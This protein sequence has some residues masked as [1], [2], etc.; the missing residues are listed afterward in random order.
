MPKSYLQSFNKMTD[1]KKNMLAADS[2]FL[3]SFLL[4]ESL[5]QGSESKPT[6]PPFQPSEKELTVHQ[7]KYE[8]YSTAAGRSF[9]LAARK[10][11]PFVSAE[12]FQQWSDF[13]IRILETAHT[14]SSLVQCFFD[15]S[16]S[17]FIK[18]S[19]T[20]LRA[21][22]EKGLQVAALSVDTAV[23][24]YELT[25]SFIELSNNIQL[26]KWGDWCLHLINRDEPES[27]LG[28]DFL[29]HSIACL[30]FMT[31]REFREYKN[32]GFKFFRIAPDI[33]KQFF[34]EVVYGLGDLD[35]TQRRTLYKLT[36]RISRLD[37][38]EAFSFFKNYPRQLKEISPNERN[39]VLST[40]EKLTHED[41]GKISFLFSGLISTLKGQPY[42]RQILILDECERII[43]LSSAA[44]QA[45]L[46]TANE[47]LSRIP[48]CFLSQF[49][50]VG[51][52]SFSAD[53]PEMAD[54]FALNTPQ[55]IRELEKFAA[56]T[57]FEDHQKTLMVLA[58]AMTGVFTDV[59]NIQ[60]LEN[61][62]DIAS[63]FHATTDGKTIY[64]P[65]FL[66]DA[67]SAKK[68]FN[69]YKI[70]TAHQAGLIEFKTFTRDLPVM[71]K[72]LS[73]LPQ[74]Q[75]AMDVF[76]ILEHGRI[77]FQLARNYAG[78]K[79]MMEQT[80]W[81][82]INQRALPETL[83]LKEAV[84]EILL[85][86]SVIPFNPDYARSFKT[87]SEYL[88][89][90]IAFLNH[91]LAGFYEQNN[92]VWYCFEKTYDI[93]HH[94][95][96]LPN[97]KQGLAEEP[98]H[99]CPPLAYRGQTYPSVL[100]EQGSEN[101]SSKLPDIMP[102]V[103]PQEQESGY[104]V[105][106]DR[107]PDKIKLSRGHAEVRPGIPLGPKDIS[108]IMLDHEDVDDSPNSKLPF[109]SQD[110]I[111]SDV[112]AMDTDGFYLY[113]EWDYVQS[114]YRKKWCRLREVKQDEG[115]LDKIN[116]IHAQ[117]RHLIQ[118]VKNQFQ[119]IKP[120]TYEN[121]PRVDWGDEIDLTAVIEGVVDKK[122]GNIPSD[123]VF[124][125]KDRK[126]QSLSVMFLV[127]MSASTGSPVIA[128][129]KSDS[130]P[131]LAREYPEQM[132]SE[133]L[134]APEKK[135]IDIEIESLVVV[136]EALEALGH[137]YAIF[138]FS[139]YGREDVTV[140]AIKA[141]DDSQ[142]DTLKKRI[143]GMRAQ[144]S[145][146]MGT[147]IR[148]ACAKL[149]KQQTEQR[150]LIL[151]S[152]GFPQDYDYGE[153]RSSYEYGIQDTMMALM[154]AKFK[155]IT[156]FCITVDHEGKDYLKKMCEPSSYLVIKDIHALPE[157]LPKVVASLIQ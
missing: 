72:M 8:K 62:S 99:A 126:K 139:G 13:G 107:L 11:I 5:H 61:T 31:F 88:S 10:V 24:Y 65:G 69:L 108:N 98:Y 67:G 149:E 101:D 118:K 35:I 135:I 91:T 40:V 58:T 63:I 96:A 157:M 68:N 113:D 102:D 27:T 14:D 38:A 152:D 53:N 123:K 74:S 25:P 84:V 106:E 93:Y 21:W 124:I 115:N 54:Y 120:R 83:P 28:I 109:Q 137:A 66:A 12:E 130:A 64:L 48:D 119:Q 71:V 26:Q 85:L 9:L 30:R 94:L 80:V 45:F 78:L 33:G 110:L 129:S 89:D 57:L 47:I 133:C 117:H 90:H 146:R 36:D 136:T 75:L 143:G 128:Q 144:K 1:D 150:L 82:E 79:R 148:H 32:L 92:S 142:G 151:L 20:Y 114:A 155:E 127:D 49:V 111:F 51:L 3:V 76:F 77:D 103:N 41:P 154:E 42:P 70:A 50:T 56:A 134:D 17:V 4:E 140:Y 46:F 125:R 132:A 100:Q 2:R 116:Q 104:T 55:A 112:P 141:F 6:K 37:A 7:E 95:K 15:A 122:S 153:D 60:K 81:R 44:G 18:T 16:E 86:Y 59:Q 22:V 156:P 43:A 23:F 138:G 147:A 131:V 19:F 87:S 34:T 52:F 39:R 73:D 145:T 121:I 97:H 29:E 105:L